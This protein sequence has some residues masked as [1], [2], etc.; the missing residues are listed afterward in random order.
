MSC[1]ENE[2]AIEMR[3]HGAL[4]AERNHALE[5]HLATCGSCRA[6]EALAKGTETMMTRQA[7]TIAGTLDW[8]SLFARTNAFVA[9]QARQRLWI[10]PTVIAALTPFMMLQ[11]HDPIR[12]A[13]SMAIAMV[14][15]TA[16][17]WLSTLRRKAE[18]ASLER[19]TG[20]LL[21]FYRSQLERRLRTMRGVIVLVPIWIVLAIEQSQ[22]VSSLREWVGL[23]GVGAVYLGIIGHVWLVRRPAIVRELASLKA[24]TK[25]R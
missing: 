20:E 4:E 12:T 2:I 14:V 16:V 11:G 13:I 1:E 15:V 18:L 8:D 23:I 24:D 9:K 7:A 25:A 3:L 17:S 19:D 6:F 10:P 22:A 21:Y 5:R